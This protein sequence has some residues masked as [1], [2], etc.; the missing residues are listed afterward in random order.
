MTVDRVSAALLHP[1]NPLLM[2]FLAT[3][4][5]DMYVSENVRSN[6]FKMWPDYWVPVVFGKF[7]FS[8][9]N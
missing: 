2:P 6:P 9:S 1:Q 3:P 8:Y 5:N 4:L 7:E